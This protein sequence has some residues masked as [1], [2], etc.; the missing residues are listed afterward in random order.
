[1][2]E[3]IAMVLV[4]GRGTRLEAMTQRTAKPAVPFL[5][6]Y[7]LIDFVLSNITNS[8]LDTVGIL[9]QYEPQGLMNYIQRGATWDLDVREGGI[10]FMTPYLSN[11]GEQFQKGTADAIKQHYYFI[12]QHQPDWVLVTSGDH[13]YKMDYRPLI[14][15]AKDH[16]VDVLIAAFQPRDALSRYGV[17]AFDAARRLTHFEEK[18]THP[19]GDHA[20]M[21]VYVFKTSALKALLFDE[22]SQGIDFGH[23]ILPLAI[24]KQLHIEVYPFSGY[25]R[26][27]GTIESY[28]EATMELLD[29]PEWIDLYDYQEAPLYSRSYDLPPHHIASPYPIRKSMIG[30]GS[31]IMGRV[32]HSV[33]AHQVLLKDNS[34]VI[35]SIVFPSVTVGE[36]AVLRNVIVLDHTVILPNTKLVYDRPT[37]IDNERLWALFGGH[38]A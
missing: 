3:T 32:E 4:G 16:N 30:D 24:E 33:I 13:V 38:D 18:P 36:N 1:M 8:G 10:Q 27:V 6:K 26:D 28:Y 11:E 20:S 7:R 19:Q 9:T 14:D 31:L 35:D 22:Q 25:F 23:D 2:K 12:E 37:L 29:H 34:F 5:S 15:Q 21:G 17:L